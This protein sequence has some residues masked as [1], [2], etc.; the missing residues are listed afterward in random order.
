MGKQYVGR[1]D[2]DV[3]L[4]WLAF[5]RDRSPDAIHWVGGDARSLPFR[6]RAFDLVCSVSALCFIDDE[7]RAAK[8]IVRVM[9]R[10][11]ACR[12]AGGPLCSL[13]SIRIRLG[14]TAR[15]DIA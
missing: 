11:F 6:D 5:A 1:D 3:D 15:D 10:R 4:E 7:H 9:N 14:K 12:Q 13:F 2:L 8:E